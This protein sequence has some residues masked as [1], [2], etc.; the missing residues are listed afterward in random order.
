[1]EKVLREKGGGEKKKK[2]RESYWAVQKGTVAKEPKFR[3]GACHRGKWEKAGE[4]FGGKKV[5][6][7]GKGLDKPSSQ[8]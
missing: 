5:I 8:K 6:G 3:K 2:K 1:L 4:K 7:E